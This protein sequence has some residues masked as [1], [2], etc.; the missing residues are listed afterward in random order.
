[1]GSLNFRG[2][3]SGSFHKSSAAKQVELRMRA[4]P[5]GWR[6]ATFL[7]PKRMDQ[8][9]LTH[10]YDERDFGRVPGAFFEELPFIVVPAG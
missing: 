10:I 8:I 9:P 6:V 1:M 5:T 4:A 2:F 7:Q 3:E